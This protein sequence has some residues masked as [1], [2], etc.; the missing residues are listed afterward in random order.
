MTAPDLAHLDELGV[1]TERT[2][3][4]AGKSWVVSGTFRGKSV[5]VKVLTTDDPHWIERQAWERRL[6]AALGQHPPPVRVPQ[7]LHST[8]RCLVLERLP[9]KVLAEP[10]YPAG[11][12]P[13]DVWRALDTLSEL[14]SW[15]DGAALGPAEIT[16]AAVID[17]QAASG[18]LLSGDR[19]RIEGLLAGLRCEPRPEH[20]DPL[21]SN[22][23]VSPGS[24]GLIDLEHTGLRLPGLDWAVIRLLWTPGNPWIAPLIEERVQQE[25]IFESYAVHLMLIACREWRVHLTDGRVPEVMQPTLAANIT[26]AREVVSLA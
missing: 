13:I 10:R 16:D 9:G 3:R 1:I 5:V 20:G 12:D 25:G 14:H 19:A 15:S 22:I 26:L 21:A 6:Y 7:L 8:D 23:L 4:Q 2:I 24:I 11:L 17:R 18:Q